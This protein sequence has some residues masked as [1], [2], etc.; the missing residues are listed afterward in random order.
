[1]TPSRG[2]TS[3]PGIL[4]TRSGSGSR[5]SS[6]ASSGSSPSP[7]VTM[8]SPS[9]ATDGEIETVHDPEYVAVVR[10]VGRAL[11]PAVWF[12]L[13]TDDDPVFEG[14]HE[15]AALVVGATLAAARSVWSGGRGARGEHR[16][17]APPR[18][19]GERQRLLRLQRPRGR[20]QVAAV[21]RGRTGGVRGPRR[22]P[23]R[24]RAGGVLRRPPGADD[25]P[26]RAPR[27][28]VPRHRAARRDGDGRR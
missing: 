9:P 14:M 24:R 10:H 8:V 6:P 12:G 22:A 17:R 26:A 5:W 3:G 13:G 27:H 16:R 28:A 15:A 25:Q 19:A 4:S 2:M 20:D 7:A 21:R 1:M 11:V 18:D 23:R